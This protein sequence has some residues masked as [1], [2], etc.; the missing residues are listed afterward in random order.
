MKASVGRSTSRAQVN[1]PPSVGWFTPSCAALIP[2]ARA[3]LPPSRIAAKMP[4]PAASVAAPTVA[5][6]PM[7]TIIPAV[8]SV[9]VNGPSS[10]LRRPLRAPSL[11]SGSPGAPAVHVSSFRDFD[12]GH[13]VDQ[14]VCQH[15]VA[16][17]RDGRVAHDVA[18]PRDRPT[19]K[20]LG[21]GIEAHDRVRGRA[22][23]AVP[24]DVVD[25]RDAVGLGL[26]PARGW[27]LGHFAGRRIE[28]TQI[29][30]REIAVPD[31]VIAGDR[32]AAWTGCR[33]RQW[34]LTNLQRLRIDTPYLVGAERDVEHGALRIHRHAIGARLGC[35][36]REQL[37]LASL[38]VE[39]P[40]PIGILCREPEDSA[41]VEDQRVRILHIRIR[42]LVLGDGA[43]LRIQLADE[44]SGVAGVPDVT[45]LVLDQ[46][47]RSGVRRLEGEFLEAAGLRIEPA[48]HIVHLPRVPER[49]IRRR[50]G[51]VWARS[52]R[53]HLP[54]L[55]RVL[56]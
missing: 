6:M 3:T 28:T 12:E 11:T 18:T 33:I 21:S 42:H 10:R 17:P 37:D 55:D 48:E 35:R 51:I 54:L 38:R 43:R 8:K 36:R 9:A 24:D 56:P 30:A 25:R 46:A 32:D 29:A 7:P 44:S 27:P 50:Q 1:A 13:G 23:L 16:I 20:F 45:V 2:V 53:G 22:G 15:E 31:D 14:A 49:A 19:L 40:H 47:M 34:V 41:L 5:K 26:R 39:A 52:G 4:L